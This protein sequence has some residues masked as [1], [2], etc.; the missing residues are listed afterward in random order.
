MLHI[1]AEIFIGEGVL[2]YHVICIHISSFC[3]SEDTYKLIV[4]MVDTNFICMHAE[5]PAVLASCMTNNNALMLL[6]LGVRK[7]TTKMRSMKLPLPLLR[8]KS[9]CYCITSKLEEK[10][11]MVIHEQTGLLIL[12]HHLSRHCLTP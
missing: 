3:V 2:Q 11:G 9:V 8:N 5:N 1:K 10:V 12:H 6:S 7:F 4:K